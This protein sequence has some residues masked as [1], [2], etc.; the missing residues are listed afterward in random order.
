VTTTTNKKNAIMIDCLGMSALDVTQSA[1]LVS[2]DTHQILLDCGLYQCGNYATAYKTN[3]RGFKRLKPQRLTAI[4]VSHANID[5]CGALP[6]LYRAGCTAPI[7]VPLGN[8]RLLS[9]MLRDSAKIIASDQQK[10]SRKTKKDVPLIYDED[11]VAATMEHVIECEMDELHYIDNGVSFR[12]IS[13]NHIVASSQ[14]S[15]NIGGKRIHYTGDIGSPFRDR[16]YTR[17]F[18]YP[19]Y[20]DVMIG[21]STYAGTLR[22]NNPSDRKKDTEK[23]LTMCRTIKENGGRILLPVFSLDRLQNIL[24]FLYDLLQDN[25]NLDFPVLVD[26]PLGSNISA[27]WAEICQ[28]DCEK[29]Q[30]VAAWKNVNFISSWEE[31]LKWQTSHQPCIILASSGMCTNGRSVAWLQRLLPSEKNYICFCGYCSPDSLGYKIKNHRESKGIAIEGKRVANKANV[32]SLLSFGSHADKNE[33]LD[34]YTECR[35]NKLLLVHGDTNEKTAFAAELQER[36]ADVGKTSRVV[37]VG[38]DYRFSL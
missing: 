12:F 23:V 34:F 31:S 7:Y 13:A 2:D 37:A 21:E 11:D 14:I 33:L 16:L 27:Q 1:Y 19:D 15:L 32:T 28:K 5:H 9:L 35:Y 3:L 25:P 29:W 4:I 24:T 6:A 10:V 38:K 22:V 18:E 36:L 8:K 17:P 20:C 30:E 26:T